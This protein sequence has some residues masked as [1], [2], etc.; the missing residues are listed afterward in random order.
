MFRFI[1]F[2]RPKS[3]KDKHKIGFTLIELLVVIAIIAI[4]AAMLLPT[5]SK[6]MERARQ[7]Y[8]INN[9]KNIYQA[10][11][12]YEQD[13]DEVIL[14]WRWVYCPYWDRNLYWISGL[15][16]YLNI[17]KNFTWTNP[18]TPLDRST[19]FYCRSDRN[20][21]RYYGDI[22]TTYVINDP[23]AG[24]T[25]SPSY[26]PKKLSR[27]RYPAECFIFGE[28]TTSAFSGGDKK[29]NHNGM[30]NICFIDGHVESLTP[31]K[32]NEKSISSK[33]WVGQ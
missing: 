27:I 25:G 8:C 26:T 19:I 7:S 20:P 15:F 30:M 4:L 23:L 18:A 29:Y 14:P 5:L 13:Y 9:L 33:F 1:F 10:F 6:T 24:D 11:F 12:L 21:S 16:P 2:V 22:A 32:V 17:K 3:M 28:A 31:Q